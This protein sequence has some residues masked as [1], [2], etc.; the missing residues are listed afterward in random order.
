MLDHGL[1]ALSI[2]WRIRVAELHGSGD[3]DTALIRR[4]G[5]TLGWQVDRKVGG[6]LTGVHAEGIAAACLYAGTH[7][8]PTSELRQ[9]CTSCDNHV[10]RL[11]AL[12]RGELNYWLAGGLDIH[13]GSADADF[14]ATGAEGVGKLV[15]KRARLEVAL[16][17]QLEYEVHRIRQVWDKVAGIGSFLVR[18][19]L[20]VAY[21]AFDIVV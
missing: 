6:I 8:K 3:A 16:V 10:V 2:E 13:H 1:H 18:H 4:A 11:Q 12:T 5:K 20:A 17:A 21:G 15:R 19:F 7:A 14:D 9:P